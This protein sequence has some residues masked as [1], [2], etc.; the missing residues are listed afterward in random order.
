MGIAISVTIAGTVWGAVDSGLVVDGKE[1]DRTSH[2]NLFPLVHN[3]KTASIVGSM[4]AALFPAPRAKRPRC[5]FKLCR[6]APFKATD[7]GVAPTDETT[8]T[9]E[10]GR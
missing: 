5:Q 2:V 4:L 8:L 6:E 3:K 9:Q 10:V 1:L 7:P